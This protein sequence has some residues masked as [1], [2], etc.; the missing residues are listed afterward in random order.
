[1]NKV[2]INQLFSKNQPC[3]YYIIIAIGSQVVLHNYT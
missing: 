1:M 3:T 2:Y